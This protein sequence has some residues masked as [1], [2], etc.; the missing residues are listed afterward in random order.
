MGDE[1][2]TSHSAEGS[3]LGFW[4]QSLYALLILAE[5][6]TDDAAIGVEQ[7]DDIELKVDGHGLLYQLKHSIA[8]KPSAVGIKSRSLWRTIKVW[9]DLLP[10][11]NLAETRL[12][13]VTVGG[14]VEGD[15]L[16]ALTDPD[17]D[18]LSLAAVM[19]QEAERVLKER[20]EAKEKGEPLPHAGRAD[21][22][23]AFLELS[24]TE[25]VSLLLRVTLK[26]DSPTIGEIEKAL[27]GH[28]TIVLPEHRQKVAERLIEWWD[29]QIV[30]SLC[31]KRA[32]AIAR[33]EYQS[34]VGEIIADLE[35]GKLVA[36]FETVAKPLEYQPDGML[37]R[38]IALVNGGPSDI[39]KAIREEWRARQ[40]RARWATENPA[41]GA[42]INEYDAILTEHWSDRHSQMAEDCADL[43]DEA[44]C[45][46]GLDL[47]R[48]SH[49]EAP[50]AVRPIQEGF[51]AAYYVRG[52]YQVLSIGLQVGWHPDYK[53]LLKDKK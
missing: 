30:Y 45:K 46:L 41:L 1:K 7:L 32:R 53:A 2:K 24:D 22:C 42:M 4:Y 17:D 52:S 16:A 40:Q 5:L 50:R 26:L 31:G 11:I 25:R 3:A 34:Q 33:T 48:W 36:D 28:L 44:K 37:T 35:Q 10:K 29:R 47:L 6:D 43:E 51:G 27:Q 20:A 18:R 39:D 9:T 49:N 8:A 23:G 19:T 12:H 21:G 38:Q 14:L 15:P 13:L